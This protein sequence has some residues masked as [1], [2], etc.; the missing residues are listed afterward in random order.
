MIHVARDRRAALEQQERVEQFFEA[1]AGRLGSAGV[2]VDQLGQTDLEVL[3]LGQG[4]KAES[5]EVDLEIEHQL[6]QMEPG[7]L[8]L[9]E[10][11]LDQ[12]SQQ[13]GAAD[14]QTA[15]EQRQTRQEA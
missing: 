7:L 9:V 12:A 13:L 1:R 6:V 8:Q 5:G 11:A 10:H 2:V 14:L 3:A 15:K 4:A